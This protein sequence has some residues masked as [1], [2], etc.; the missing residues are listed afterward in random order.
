MAAA[1]LAEPLQQLRVFFLENTCPDIKGFESTV[2][3]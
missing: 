2:E 3:A 1:L